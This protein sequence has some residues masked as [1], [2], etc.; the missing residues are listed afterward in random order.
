MNLRYSC[1]ELVRGGNLSQGGLWP[2]FAAALIRAVAHVS[3][4]W[5]YCVQPRAGRLFD[6]L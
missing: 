5:I 1:N 3:G 6:G 4:M 2:D